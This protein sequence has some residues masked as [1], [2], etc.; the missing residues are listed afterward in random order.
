MN[1]FNIPVIYSIY[2]ELTFMSVCKHARDINNV[3]GRDETTENVINSRRKIQTHVMYERLHTWN[4]HKSD[5][6]IQQYD[7]THRG[8]K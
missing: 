3:K 6:I 4:Q 8:A 5:C 7:D 1:N 2:R